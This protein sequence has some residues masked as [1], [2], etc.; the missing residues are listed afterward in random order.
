MISARWPER[1]RNCADCYDV[2]MS[3]LLVDVGF[4]LSHEVGMS[5]EVPRATYTPSKLLSERRDPI[6]LK[7]KVVRCVG[8]S[9][10]KGCV[11]C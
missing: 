3:R 6:I 4:Q 1:N 9:E 11:R 7:V 2:R 5:Q 10:R 8:V